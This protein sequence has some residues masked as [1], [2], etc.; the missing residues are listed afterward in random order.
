MCEVTIYIPDEVLSGRGMTASDATELAR[1]MTAVGL[2][3][4]C[5]VSLGHCA[6]IAHMPKADFIR[7][8]GRFGVSIFHYDDEAELDEE[9]ANA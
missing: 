9:L 2:F 4:I 3:A 6:E 7:L 1:Q 8:L 5:G